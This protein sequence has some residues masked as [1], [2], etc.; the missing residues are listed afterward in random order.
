[1]RKSK[2]HMLPSAELDYESA[3]EGLFEKNIDSAAAFVDDIERAKKQ[4]AEHPLSAPFYIDCRGKK[5]KYRRLV[6]KTGYNLFYLYSDSDIYVY[7]IFHGRQNVG[8]NA[9]RT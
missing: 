7:R 6:R 4:L 1:M 9:F 2:V 3:F 5:T 8:P